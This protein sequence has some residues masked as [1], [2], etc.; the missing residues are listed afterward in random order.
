MNYLT[1]LYVWCSTLL[2]PLRSK[3]GQTMVEYALILALIAII[4]M[5]AASFLGS[6]TTSVY[7]KVANTLP[8]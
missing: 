5:A 3:K 2:E 6:K 7:S 1:K 4:V 8:T